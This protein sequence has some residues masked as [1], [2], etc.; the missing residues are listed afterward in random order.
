MTNQPSLFD[1][2][3]PSG[4][5]KGMTESA[6]S[7]EAKWTPD[8]I[9]QVDRAIELCHHFQP[10]FTADDIWARLPKDF[11]VTKG[12]ASRLNVAAR[13]GLIQATDRTRKAS[14]GGD[15]DHGQRLTIWRSL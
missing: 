11:P 15:H 8:Q 5:Q 14:R 2:S 6:R 10:E 9:A 12:L 1:V 4:F 3:T 7:A 13:K